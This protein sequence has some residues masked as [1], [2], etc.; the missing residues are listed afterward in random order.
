M[1]RARG[2]SAARPAVN[3]PDAVGLR[4]SV[5]QS[6][7]SRPLRFPL[8]VFSPSPKNESVGVRRRANVNASFN[9]A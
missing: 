8:P 2:S 4:T 5:F 6:V 9:V 1:L 3:S 7:K